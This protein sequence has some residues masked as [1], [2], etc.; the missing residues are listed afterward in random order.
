[1]KR[2]L[3]TSIAETDSDGPAFKLFSTRDE[4][5]IT[6]SKKT[7]CYSLSFGTSHRS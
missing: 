4:N 5:T 6:L 7:K 2:H 3:K 1:M